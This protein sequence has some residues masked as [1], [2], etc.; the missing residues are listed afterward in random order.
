MA[1]NRPQKWI[2][3]GPKLGPKSGSD[4]VPNRGPKVDPIWSKTGSKKW[5]RFGPKPNP[6]SDHGDTGR[7]VSHK[8]CQQDL[9]KLPVPELPFDVHIQN[10]TNNIRI[11]MVQCFSVFDGGKI[12][13][14]FFR[15][16][17]N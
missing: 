2:R 9:T 8:L 3:F 15:W 5:I 7:R 11:E 17:K 6:K 16:G 4:L 14:Q 1:P 13:I 12:V 10:N